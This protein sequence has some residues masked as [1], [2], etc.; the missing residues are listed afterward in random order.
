MKIRLTMSMITFALA[1]VGMAVRAHTCATAANS[2]AT[3]TKATNY[4]ATR[5]TRALSPARRLSL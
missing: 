3:A 4:Q 1:V 2:A 5:A